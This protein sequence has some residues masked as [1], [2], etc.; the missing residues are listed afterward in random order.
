M[1][2]FIRCD[3]Y[4][5]NTARVCNNYLSDCENH[6]TSRSSSSIPWSLLL[7]SST[8]AGIHSYSTVESTASPMV[9]PMTV[10]AGV[11]LAHPLYQEMP[12]LD[13]KD[14][15]SSAVGMKTRDL[16]MSRRLVIIVLTTSLNSTS[17]FVRMATTS[18]SDK[19]AANSAGVLGSTVWST[20]SGTLLPESIMKQYFSVSKSETTGLTVP[21]KMT[22]RHLAGLASSDLLILKA[23]ERME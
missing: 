19:S 8:A 23:E 21:W 9:H 11:F 3:V 17:R 2:A 13:E 14:R 7:S 5:V 16:A 1:G 18:V 12:G 22:L 4:K 6:S 10:P 20:T 15:Q